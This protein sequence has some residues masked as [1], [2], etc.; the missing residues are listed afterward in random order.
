MKLKSKDASA[1][2]SPQ[3]GKM[4]TKILQ[5]LERYNPKEILFQNHL[6][7]FRTMISKLSVKA[8][9][10]ETPRCCLVKAYNPKSYHVEPRMTTTF[11]RTKNKVIKPNVR[12]RKLP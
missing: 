6:K 1:T 3:T 4:D 2:Q 8:I 10:N 9:Q 5:H 7:I 12:V 11:D